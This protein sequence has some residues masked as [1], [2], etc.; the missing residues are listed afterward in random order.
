MNRERITNYHIASD[1]VINRRKERLKYQFQYQ[2]KYTVKLTNLKHPRN[3][4]DR[5]F[6]FVYE[7]TDICN[8]ESIKTD[9]LIEYLKYHHLEKFK[10]ISFSQAVKDVKNFLNVRNKLISTSTLKM[11]LSVQNYY[12][13]TRI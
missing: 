5:I 4:L 3:S 8:V 12:L 2:L 6:W 11:D 13:W 9:T 7:Y 10:Q 1:L